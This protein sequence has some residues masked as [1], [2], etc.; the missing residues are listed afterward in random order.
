MT[1]EAAMDS[2]ITELSRDPFSVVLADRIL[3]LVVD[4]RTGDILMRGAILFAWK[5]LVFS[6]ISAPIGQELRLQYRDITIDIGST[7]DAE[8]AAS[9]VESVNAFL[10]T[11]RTVEPNRNGA[12]AVDVN[13]IVA[14][15]V[16]QAV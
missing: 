13:V 8:A 9:W 1:E 3:G 2:K 7:D 12:H 16:D 11:K 10:A 14:G 15:G 4:A 6:L 5:G